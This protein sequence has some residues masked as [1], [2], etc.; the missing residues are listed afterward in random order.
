ML[1]TLGAQFNLFSA[2][3]TF[4]VGV[5]SLMAA[6]MPS[7]SPI[8][9]PQ[10]IPLNDPATILLTWVGLTIVGLGMAGFYH[11][12]LSQAAR[13]A[14]TYGSRLSLWL[15]I[16]A[17]AGVVYLGL[18]VIGFV[19]LVAA[20]L[21]TLVTPFLGTGVAFLG[22]SLVFWLAVY[23]VFTPHGLVRHRLGVA[24]AMRESV[25]LVRRNFFTTVAFLTVVL[26]LSW[27]TEL[28]WQLPSAESWFSALAALGHAFVSAML[29]VASYIFY[30]GRREAMLAAER[31]APAT[32][33]SAL[34]GRD[35]RGA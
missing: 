17:M 26:L 8:G 27:L 35:A 10:V 9:D 33:G 13:P 24:R 6:T 28:V 21:V 3:S 5:P 22:F 32:D 4:P 12:G 20:S 7:T 11:V 19:S 2:L 30:V 34:D 31:P 23:L 15:R 25:R 29:L 1:E 16:L 14:G 18:A